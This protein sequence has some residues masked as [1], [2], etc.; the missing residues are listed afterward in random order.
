[1]LACTGSLLLVTCSKRYFSIGQV[2]QLVDVAIVD[3]QVACVL[4]AH[5]RLNDLHRIVSLIPRLVVLI[6][7][8]TQ[9]V[10]H[11]NRRVYVFQVMG[12][13][14][15]K[16]LILLSGIVFKLRAVDFGEAVEEVV[17]L[18]LLSE[19]DC[20]GGRREEYLLTQHVGCVRQKGH[21]RQD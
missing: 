16:Q 13:S 15:V 6:Q 10:W 1:M 21:H 17:W 11:L 5:T 4:R 9:L 14:L 7:W 8:L 12:V 19:H 20:I 3:A 18:F 2:L